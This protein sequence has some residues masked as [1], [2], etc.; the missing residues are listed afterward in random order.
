MS[1]LTTALARDAAVRGSTI[2]NSV[3]SP[4]SVST[5]IEP[6][7]CFTMMSWLMRQAEPGTFSGR[8]G[9]E[10]R[11]EHLFLYLGCYAGAIVANPDF[12][13]IARFL[14]AAASVGS[15]SPAPVCPLRLVAA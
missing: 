14:V 11:I 9:G 7:C 13:A 1:A 15:N 10:E 12:D 6:A 4:G 8:L 3:N 5:A 2:L